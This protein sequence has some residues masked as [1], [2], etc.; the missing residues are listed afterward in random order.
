M[1]SSDLILLVNGR[2][3][4][5]NHRCGPF[6]FIEKIVKQLHMLASNKLYLL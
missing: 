2:K 3:K 6:F 1:V 5:Q 4:A